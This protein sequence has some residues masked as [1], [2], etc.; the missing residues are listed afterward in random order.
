MG[1]PKLAVWKF[2]SC[3]GCQLQL[4]DLE[5]DLLALAR[6]VD[7]ARFLEASSRVAAG[8]Y[9]V[10]FVEGSVSAPG[11]V[12]RLKAIRAQ[13]GKLVAIGACA[14]TGGVQA[15]RNAASAE[16]FAAAVYPRPEA[17]P[18]LAASTPVSAH[19]DVDFEIQGCPVS[20]TQVLDTLLALLAGRSPRLPRHPQCVECKAAGTPCVTVLAGAPCLGP[21]TRAGCGN[22]CPAVGR[23]CYGCFGPADGADMAAMTRQLKALGLDSREIRD[24]FRGFNAGSP[25]FAEAAANAGTE[26]PRNG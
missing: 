10:S 17:V 11:D 20:K 2:A 14:T 21:V 25:A 22:L 7:I 12:E 5:E 19:V 18:T 16:A 24:A 23:G 3:D 8:P 6:R 13:S 26:R 4:L 1:R 15:A 9:D